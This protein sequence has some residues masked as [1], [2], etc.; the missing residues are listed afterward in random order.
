MREWGGG[1]ESGKAGK[2]ESEGVREW[3]GETPSSP[4]KIQSIQPM[5]HYGEAPMHP[6]REGERE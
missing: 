1:A 3:L 6:A 4:E 2:R 5:E